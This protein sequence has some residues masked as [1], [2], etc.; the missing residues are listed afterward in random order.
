VRGDLIEVF[1]IL[2]GF[3]LVDSTRFFTR[4]VGVT[5]G[6]ELKLLK[7]GCRLDCKRFAFGH[8]VVDNWNSLPSDVIACNTISGFK[9]GLDKFLEGRGFI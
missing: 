4:N 3:D 8:R 1:K 9:K 5:R 7:A 2:K 6:H